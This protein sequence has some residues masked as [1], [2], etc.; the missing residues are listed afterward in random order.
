LKANE[1]YE[2]KSIFYLRFRTLDDDRFK[3]FNVKIM[4]PT[5]VDF[6]WRF[7]FGDETSTEIVK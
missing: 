2:V 1:N 7:T 5:R 6:D 4:S 3:E